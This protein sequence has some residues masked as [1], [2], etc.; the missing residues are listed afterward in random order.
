[1]KVLLLF[2]VLVHGV[3]HTMAFLKAF[4]LVEFN[5]LTQSISKPVRLL[6]LI[7]TISF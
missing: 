1:M 7:T 5:Q 3:I 2:V 6:W 4:D